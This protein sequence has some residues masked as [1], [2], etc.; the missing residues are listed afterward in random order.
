MSAAPWYSPERRFKADTSFRLDLDLGITPVHELPFM[1]G[2]ILLNEKRASLTYLQFSAAEGEYGMASSKDY[3]EFILDQLSELEDVAYRPMMG[4]YILYYRGKA[5]GGIYDDRFLVKPTKS[6]AALMP[7]AERELPYE[8][9]KEMFLVDDVENRRFL[10]E[11]LQAV[12][13]E[14]PAPKKKKRDAQND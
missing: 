2:V 8:G 12:H 3:L 11:L 10:R 9:G 6:A 4:E 7:D 5:I 14:L 1:A 13:A